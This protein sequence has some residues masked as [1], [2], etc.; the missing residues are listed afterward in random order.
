MADKTKT[1]V[2]RG[3]LDWAKVTGKARP[4]TGEPRYD[5]GP[6]WSVDVT[7]NAE[8]MALIKQLG[9]T[10]KLRDPSPKDKNRKGE[11]KF[12]SLR[13]LENK[14]DGSKNDPPKVVDLR[15]DDWNGSNLGN[16]TIGDVKVRVVDYGR[17]IPKGVY[18]QAIR[19][20]DHVPYEEE[21]F[22]P[23]SEDDEFFAETESPSQDFDDDDVPA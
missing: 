7:P 3:T 17:S 4:H 2:I 11:G 23:L 10:E 16:G 21:A 20:L 1:V 18:L 5:K 12:L 6:F 15:G 22:K 13:V 8:S 14:P 19:V 9:L